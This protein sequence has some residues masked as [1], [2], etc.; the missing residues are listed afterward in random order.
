MQTAVSLVELS[1]NNTMYRQTDGVSMES[2]LGPA[3]A[4]IIVG[5]QETKLFL[6]IKKPFV[7]CRYVDDTFAV[8]ESEEKCQEFFS[9]FF[10]FYV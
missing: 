3:L 9:L 1:F 6:N 8:F 4:N 10:T 7:Y 5:Y 2:Q